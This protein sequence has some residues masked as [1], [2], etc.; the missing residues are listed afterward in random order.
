MYDMI[1]VLGLALGTAFTAGIN[2]YATVATLGLAARAA[3]IAPAG[4][5]MN[6]WTASHALSRY[7][8]LSAKNSTA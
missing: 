2:L 5:R 8:V 6:V 7:G 3:R 1:G 4:T